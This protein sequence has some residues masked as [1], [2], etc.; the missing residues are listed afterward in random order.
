M[1]EGIFHVQLMNLPCFRCGNA[2]N[3]S[4][5]GWFDDGAERFFIVDAMLLSEPM[6]DPV[7][8]ISCKGT[9]RVVFVL[10]DA[11]SRNNICTCR[12][13]NKTPHILIH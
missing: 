10:K 7:S 6:Y 2:D 13:R 12:F 9:V 5:G 11:L 8:F 3:N 4:D 1:Q